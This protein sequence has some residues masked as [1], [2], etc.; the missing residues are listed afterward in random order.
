MLLALFVIFLTMAAGALLAGSL[1]YRMILLRE[2]VQD[3][4]LTAISDAGIA[5]ALD[6]LVLS[7]FWTGSLQ[8]EIGDGTV[9]VDISNSNRVMV[10]LVDV[11]AVYGTGG[12]ALRAEIQVDDYSPPRVIS[13]KPQPY[14]PLPP[15]PSADQ[16]S[17]Y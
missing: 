1:N 6:Q 4:H 11:T 3:V 2:E 10:R 13:W 9:S 16:V 8:R 5:L 15:A 12:R 17:V 7:P 14:H